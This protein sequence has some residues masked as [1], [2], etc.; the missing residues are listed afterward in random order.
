MKKVAIIFGGKSVEHDISI[1]TALQMM[2]LMKDKY[3]IFPVYIKTNGQMCTADNL[4]EKELFLDYDGRVKNEKEV[5]IPF[6]KNEFWVLQKGKVKKKFSPEMALLCCHGGDGENGCL[7]GTLD[8]AGIC[9]TSPDHYS[10]ALCMNKILTKIILQDKKIDVVPYVKIDKCE[11][12]E[13]KEACLEKIRR[14]LSSK[15]IIKPATGGSSVGVVICEDKNLLEEKLEYAFSFDSQIIIENFVEEM[16]EYFCA[17]IKVGDKLFESKIDCVKG[18]EFF[19]FEE[20]YL[21]AKGEEGETVSDKMKERIYRQAK[22]SVLALGCDGVVRVDFIYDKKKDKLFT[23]EINTIPGA[24]SFHLFDLSIT[25]FVEALIVSAKEKK[26]KKTEIVY[27]FSSPAIEK[28]IS[29][30]NSIKTK[31]IN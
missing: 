1:I 10:S 22:E 16:E 14:E 13:N 20:K 2:S 15:V 21:Q 17:I 26:N 11:H 29:I 25:D 5:L 27:K 6:G 24:L 30:S 4:T 8:M 23:S 28:Y 12:V 18:G 3:N 7:Q 31:K 9:Y 19:S